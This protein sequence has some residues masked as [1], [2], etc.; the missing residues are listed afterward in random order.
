MSLSQNPWRAINPT[1][2]PYVLADDEPHILAFNSIIG[3]SSHEYLDLSLLP[4]PWVGRLDAPVIVLNLNPG[5]SP[6]DGA[7]HRRIDVREAIV[8]NLRQERERFPLIYLDPRIC[9]DTRRDVVVALTSSA[10][11]AF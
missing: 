5:R 1:H 2:P 4:D 10:D 8:A 3:E 9:R 6:G 11:S 7:A